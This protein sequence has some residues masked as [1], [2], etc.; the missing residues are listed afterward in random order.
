MNILI[1]GANSA[2]ARATARLYA[3]HGHSFYLVGRDQ[4]RLDELCSDLKVRGAEQVH[5]SSLDFLNFEEHGP[6]ISKVQETLKQVDLTLI[7]HGSLPDRD[8]CETD[9]ERTL[10][11]LAINGTSVISLINHLLPVYKSQRQGMLAVVTSVAGDRGRQPNYL[12]G[13]AKSLVSTYLQGLRGRLLPYGVHVLDIRPGLVDSPMT[14][15]FEK[16]PL[17][18]TPE[19]VAAKIV[20]AV[21][22]QKHVIYVPGYWRLIMAIVC[23]I[24]ETLF[25]RLK[26]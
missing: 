11:E 7:C 19:L 24:P 22:K 9:L 1:L 13:A 21:R 14:A 26:F 3:E 23:S 4:S 18:S 20:T 15:G 8:A 17:W 16:G 2:I 6:L 5:G 12:Y 10:Q 25:K